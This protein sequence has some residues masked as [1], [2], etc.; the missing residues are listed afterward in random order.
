LRCWVVTVCGESGEVGV[1]AAGDGDEASEGDDD[2]DVCGDGV[3]GGCSVAG[4][5][6]VSSARFSTPEDVAESMDGLDD[7][8]AAASADSLGSG[9]VSS[10]RSCTTLSA[11]LR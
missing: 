11:A 8:A 10:P 1:D 5:V 9:N 6:V 2:D 3:S 4:V 7:T